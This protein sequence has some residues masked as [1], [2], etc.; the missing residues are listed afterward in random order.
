MPEPKQYT[1]G[2]VARLTVLTTRLAVAI[3]TGRGVKAADAAIERLQAD[4]IA[5]EQAEERAAAAARQE[6]AQAKADKR[7]ARK[8][9]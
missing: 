2:E 4:A 5:R 3:G 9:F 8:W 1:A 7:A 6:K